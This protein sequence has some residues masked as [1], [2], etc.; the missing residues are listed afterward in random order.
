MHACTPRKKKK[1]HLQQM[2]VSLINRPQITKNPQRS[3]LNIQSAQATYTHAILTH[4]SVLSSFQM[5][6]LPQMFALACNAP[7]MHVRTYPGVIGLT[8]H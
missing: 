6:S 1:K 5:H 2:I 8:A 3:H 4:T 7:A